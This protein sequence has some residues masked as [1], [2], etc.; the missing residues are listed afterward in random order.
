VGGGSASLVRHLERVAEE[1]VEGDESSSVCVIASVED[2][3]LE[4]SGGLVDV[5]IVPLDCGRDGHDAID[6]VCG[7]V[8]GDG[9][10]QVVYAACGQAPS[11][12]V[13][14]TDHA[15]MLPPDADAPDMKLALSCAAER[16]RKWSEHPFL[17]R[18]KGGEK[19]IVPRRVSYVESDRRIISVHLTDEVVE[20]YSK[21]SDI[22]RLLPDRFV[23]CHKS[24]LVNMGFI[25]EVDRESIL[26][27]TGERIPMSQR[28]R[29]QTRSAFHEFVGKSLWHD[30]DGHE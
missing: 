22:Q 1:A 21:L 11:A 30:G 23:Q 15:Y 8:P 3:V 17:L 6:L 14:L 13:Y 10:V 16:L 4:I 5:L 18:A 7:L 20:A 26:L 25:D 27:T 2:L 9:C 29:T 12:R 19:L 24:F 28:R